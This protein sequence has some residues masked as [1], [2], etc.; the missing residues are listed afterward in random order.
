MEMHS[1]PWKIEKGQNFVLAFFYLLPAGRYSR[2]A[3]SSMRPT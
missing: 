1:S 2:P 3:S